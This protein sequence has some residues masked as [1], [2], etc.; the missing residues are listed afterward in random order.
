MYSTNQADDLNLHLRFSVPNNFSKIKLSKKFGVEGL[1]A[2]KLLIK[3]EK[4]ANKIGVSF[5]AEKP[6]CVPYVACIF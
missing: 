2:E 5:H 6:T 4:V 3:M 1:A